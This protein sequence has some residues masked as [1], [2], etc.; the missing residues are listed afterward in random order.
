[1]YDEAYIEETR[2]VSSEEYRNIIGKKQGRAVHLWKIYFNKDINYLRDSRKL[3]ENFDCYSMNIKHPDDSRIQIERQSFREGTFYSTYTYVE[4]E[5]CAKILNGDIAWMEKSSDPL[6]KELFVQM[7]VNK[8]TPGV[9]VQY[10]REIYRMHGSSDV[11][12]FDKSIQSSYD[13]KP[14]QL[15]QGK[16]TLKERL[17]KAFYAMTYHQPVLVPRVVANILNFREGKKIIMET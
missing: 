8:I 3:T 11:I 4:R 5:K 12:V 1:M 7:D 16:V 17:P 14:K 13:F 9:I 10:E 2:L 15:I 6:L